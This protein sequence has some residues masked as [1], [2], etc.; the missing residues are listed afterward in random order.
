ML[1]RHVFFL[2]TLS[3]I[4][5]IHTLSPCY[6]LSNTISYNFG[7]DE[8]FL[9]FAKKKQQSLISLFLLYLDCFIFK[10]LRISIFKTKATQITIYSWTETDNDSIITRC[11]TTFILQCVSVHNYDGM[12]YISNSTCPPFL[13]S[14]PYSRLHLCLYIDGK[15]SI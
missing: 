12:I 2:Y 14:L 10:R 8:V 11:L 13:F 3:Y 15:S 4:S 9:H 5:L 6:S 7:N 1:T